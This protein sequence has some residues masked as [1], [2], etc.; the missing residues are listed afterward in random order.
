MTLT[1]PAPARH[2]ARREMIPHLTAF[3]E[4]TI[5]LLTAQHRLPSTRMQQFRLPGH[6]A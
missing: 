4:E 1:L 6:G 2:E 3:N 5:S